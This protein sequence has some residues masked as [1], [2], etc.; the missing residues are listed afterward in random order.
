MS[1]T[2]ADARYEELMNAHRE[3]TDDESAK[4]NCALILLLAERVADH[5]LLRHC[6]AQARAAALENTR[7]T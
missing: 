3:L 6:I 7:G 5:E 1:M 4:L 2:D